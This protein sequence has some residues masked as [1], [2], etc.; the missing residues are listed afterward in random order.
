M[1]P[2]APKKS[3]RIGPPAAGVAATST[4]RRVSAGNM[5]ASAAM[6]AASM[7]R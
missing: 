2:I 1:E 5:R 7:E 3:A 4:D 6:D